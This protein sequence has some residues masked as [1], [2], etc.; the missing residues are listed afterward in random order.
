MMKKAFL[1]LALLMGLGMGTAFAATDTVWTAAKGNGGKAPAYWYSYVYGTGATID[2]NVI[3][4]YKVIDFSV[5]KTG[6]NGAGYGF[7]WEQDAAYKDVPISLSS[8]KGVCL[9]YKADAPVRMDFKQ[10]TIGDDNYYG[11][12]LD[13]S[14]TFKKVFVS[15]DGLTQDWKSASTVA[16]NANKQMGIQFGYKNTMVSRYGA[17]NTLTLSSIILGDACATFAPVVQEPYAGKNPLDTN[18]NEMDTL[19]LELSKVFYDDDGDDLEVS[20]KIFETQYLTLVNSGTKFSL[21][22][23]LRFVP[24][25][26]KN[27]LASVQIKAND[28]KD[29]ASYALSVTVT[30]AENPP[31]AVDDFYSVKEDSVLDVELLK[32]VLVND[33]DVDGDLFSMEMSASTSHGTLSLNALNGSFRYEP[34]ANFC[35]TDTWKYFLTDATGKVGTPATVTLSVQCVNDAPTVDVKDSSVIKNLVYEEDF[36]EKNVSFTESEILFSDVDG[37]KLVIGAYGDSRINAS[38]HPIGSVYYILFES[39]EDANGTAYVTLFATDKSDTAKVV[40]PVTITPKKDVP[41]AF[42][43]TYDMF[44]DSVV[45]IAAASGVLKNDKN[46][47]DPTVALKAYLKSDAKNGKVVLKTDGSFT[48][49]PNADFVG[50]DS[51]TY[52][53]VNSGE[54]TSNV[55]TVYLD[56][57]DM[58]DPPVIAFDTVSVDTFVRKEDFTSTILFTA[59]VTSGW[60]TDPDKDKIYLNVKSDDGK[61]NPSLSSAG[62]LSIKAVKDSTG[63]AYVT[64]TATDSISGS[65]SF[66]IHVFL[67][68]VNDKPVA[69]KRQDTL[70]V[71]TMGFKVE[72][73]LDSVFM[74]PDGDSLAYALVNVNKLFAAKIEGSLLTIT[75]AEDS[76]S[77]KPELYV[78]RVTATD[79]DETSATAFIYLDVGGTVGFVPKMAAKQ[80][81]WQ[82]AIL[83]T[84][85]TAKLYDLKGHLL[86]QGNLPVSEAD[87]RRESMRAAGKTVLR[88]NRS[89]WILNSETFR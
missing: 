79:S 74:D 28:G 89:H 77:I 18:L 59:K 16:W 13:P 70:V 5:S 49:T 60:F 51:F 64:V 30:D 57:L 37:D 69:L 39:V 11:T 78:I 36:G 81:R 42:D 53:V 45:T 65:A 63:D 27:G 68:P 54:D 46:P 3:N 26:N 19:K 6:S 67:E 14:S 22:D 44:E 33:F 55:A 73:D 35:G 43:D 71:D 56:V 50:E 58:N 85:G 24:V 72:V 2:T 8:Y 32:G 41:K 87:V 82:Q 34:V 80:L 9:V 75:P 62:I 21:K 15:F 48:Y 17:T 31:T 88:L 1:K 10:S 47:D 66:R 25:A 76:V 83:E 7:G 12:L 84:R 61:L 4:S 20:V 52:Y 38:V 23:T 86:W 40:F 29:T